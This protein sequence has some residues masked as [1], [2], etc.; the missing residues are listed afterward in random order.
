MKKNSSKTRIVLPGNKA[1]DEKNVVEKNNNKTTYKKNH[2]SFTAASASPSGHNKNPEQELQISKEIY[3]SLFYQ[4]PA[5]VFSM[6]MEGNITSANHILA[7]KAECS[8]EALLRLHYTAFVHPQDLTAI[9]QYFAE[10]KQGITHEFEMRIITAKNNLLHVTMIS[11]PI[12]VSNK[13]IGVFCIA[14]DITKEK[15]AVALLNKTLADRQRILDFSLDMICEFDREGKFIQVSKACKEIL[16]YLP[17]ELIGKQSIDLVIEEDKP[18]TLDIVK[19]I[20]SGGVS[21]SNFENRYSR[22]DGHV[23][24]LLWSVRWDENDKTMYCIAKDATEI[25]GNEQALGLSEQRYRYLFNNNPMPLFI[26]DFSTLDIIEVNDAAI[27][28]YGYSMQEFIGLNIVDIRPAGDINLL[29]EV[30]KDENSYSHVNEK[31]WKHLKKNG[32]LMYMQITGNLIDYKG[33]RCVLTLLDDVTEKIKAE[34]KTRDS[35]D[36]RRLIMN[37][38]LDAI[39]CMDTKGCITFWNPQ[40]EKI[41]GWKEGE[42]M[43]SVLSE[44]VIPER[45]RK[46]HE[47][48]MQKYL[49]TGDAPMLNKILNLSAVNKYQKEFSIEL[50]VQFVKEG[51]EE[52][53]CSFIRDVTAQRKAESLKTFE[54]RDKEALINSTGDLIWS[55]SKDLKLI[56]GNRAFIASFKSDTGL[57]IKQGDYLLMKNIFSDELL[58]FWHEMYYKALSGETFKKEVLV[59][60]TSAALPQWSEVSFNP[61]YDGNTITGVACYSRN[62]TENKLHQNKLLAINKKLETAQQMAKLG[63]WE[64]DLLQNTAFWSDELF[65]I[66]RFAKTAFPIPIQQIIDA[67]H[68]ADKK[69]VLQQYARVIKEKIPYHLEHRIILKDG[70]IKVLL[71]KGI[72]ICDE[73]GQPVRLEGTSQDISFQKLTEKTIKDSEEKYRMIFNSSPLPNWIYDV[74]TLQIMEVNDAAIKHYGYSGAAFLKM[75]IKELFI[76]EEISFIIQM[77]KEIT[78][79]GIL[80]FGQWQHKKKSG[81]IINVDITGHCIYYN[82]KNAVMM[83]SND[84][85]GI[86]ESRQALVKSMERFEYATKATSDAIWDCDLVNDTIFWGEGFSTLFGYKL[87]EREPGISSWQAFIHPHDKERVWQSLNAVINDPE[88]I[89]WKEDYRFKKFDGNYA[90]VVDCALVIRDDNGYPYRIIGAIQDISERIQNEIMLKELNDQL[91]K[92]A[93]ELAGS[94]EELEQ[95]AY[96]ASHDLQEPLRMVTGFLTQLQ[97]KYE[98]QLDETGRKYIHFAVDGAVRMRKIIQDLLE[99]SRVGRQKYQYEK[100]DTNLLLKDVAGVYSNSI[101]EKKMEI[102]WKNLPEITAAKIPIQQLFQNL[103]GNAVKYQQPGIIPKINISGTEKEDHWH[104]EV[105]DNGI[106]IE[107]EYFDKIFVIFQRLHH[108]DEYTGTG[109]GLAI[110]KKIVDN[111]KGKIWVASTPGKGSSFYFDIPKMPW[112]LLPV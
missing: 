100:I 105:S 45:H 51:G 54:R 7:L 31:I 19:N 50:T 53:F 41:F 111:H 59:N 66:Y 21:T 9:H 22:K 6:D 44:L 15:N 24:N 70:S 73:E 92:R 43:G 102:C 109:I 83:V 71:Q 75:T 61:I 2:P 14:N 29:K 108:K 79:N 68:P 26:F 30:L 57:L 87:K 69:H 10:A 1:T 80:N 106:G 52:F 86:I 65:G 90:T 8:E 63:Y 78:N 13:I 103:I 101:I 58:L 33:R 98:L 28:K 35:E 20:S 64:I 88:K 89:Y 95:F 27:K 96:I 104:F 3:Q 12:I 72:L 40:A 49:N 55:V 81:T 56:A 17:E 97:K 36:K 85:T 16:G 60:K 5:A 99:Y 74:A 11:M 25:R 4:N 93:G 46:M 84:I 76:A 34:K 91:N 94:N 112:A 82:N 77:N 107:A 48:G 67:I 23:V 62:I 37:A 110:C 47:Q 18:A 39:I 32:E 38:A 42:V